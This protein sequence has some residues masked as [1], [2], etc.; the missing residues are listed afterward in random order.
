M[1]TD[2]KQIVLVCFVIFAALAFFGLYVQVRLRSTDVRI[3]G[4]RLH[5]A[6]EVARLEKEISQLRKLQRELT[7]AG[8][9]A[10]EAL[11]KET[12]NAKRIRTKAESL[13][14]QNKAM[15]ERLARAMVEKKALGQLM[16]E[17]EARMQSLNVQNAGLQKEA[18]LLRRN[19]DVA[20]QA[21]VRLA[22]VQEA[23]DGLIVEKGKENIL[24]MQMDAL[25]REVE[26]I[27]QYLLE[28]RDN[29]IAPRFALAGRRRRTISRHPRGQAGS[30]RERRSSTSSRSTTSRPGSTY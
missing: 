12:R 29:R 1:R 8:L 3:E 20:M 19:F 25:I 9:T 30:I 6:Q 22:Q 7:E 10:N 17:L 2:R 26:D 23:I 21:R 15:K 14:A 16:D 28:I 27:N 4:Q 18:E 11:T 13:M 5:E 24:R